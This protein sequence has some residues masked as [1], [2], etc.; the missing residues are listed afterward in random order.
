MTTFKVG[1]RV[2]IAAEPRMH[3]GDPSLN[4]LMLKYLGKK[5]TI[6]EI[7]ESTMVPNATRIV[8]DIDTKWVWSE[9]WLKKISRG[10]INLANGTEL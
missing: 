2:R 4:S 8:L 5:A 1:D 7:R 10:K 9:F 3:P 6:K